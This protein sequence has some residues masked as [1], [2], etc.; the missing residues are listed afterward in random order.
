MSLGDKADSDWSEEHKCLFYNHQTT[1]HINNSL[2]G[3]NKSLRKRLKDY[4]LLVESLDHG[5]QESELQIISL[6]R[7]VSRLQWHLSREKS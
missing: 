1:E 4:A 3:I 7:E 5:L 2:K 6:K